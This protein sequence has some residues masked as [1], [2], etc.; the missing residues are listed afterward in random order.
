MFGMARLYAFHSPKRRLPPRRRP[1]FF[2]SVGTHPRGSHWSRNPVPACLFCDHAKCMRNHTSHKVGDASWVAQQHCSQSC[3]GLNITGRTCPPGVTQF[4][5][6]LPGISGYYA[7][8]CLPAAGNHG[9]AS[10]DG[11][12]GFEFSIVDKVVVP[13]ALTAGEYYWPGISIE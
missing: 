13:A 7:N 3:S 11:L 2:V 6:V 5:E 10:C 12:A 8:M 9:Q 4:P 1:P